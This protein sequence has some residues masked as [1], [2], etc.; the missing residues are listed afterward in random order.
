AMVRLPRDE[1]LVAGA[2]FL[3]GL[4]IVQAANEHGMHPGEVNALCMKIISMLDGGAAKQAWDLLNAPR[5]LPAGNRAAAEAAPPSP[6][7]WPQDLYYLDNNGQRFGPFDLA[8]L[9]AKVRDGTLTRRTQ[10]Y[11]DGMT[12]WAAAESVPELH[13]L[14]AEVPSPTG[15]QAKK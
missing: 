6:P 1:R 8:N 12:D 15:A 13:S 14:F 3:R 10:V 5:G 2:I 4:S 11:K 9:A 7:L